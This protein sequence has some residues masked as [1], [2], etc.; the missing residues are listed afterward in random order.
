MARWRGER[1]RPVYDRN[2]TFV[3]GGSKTLLASD[4]DALTLVAAGITVHT[5][6]AAAK[7][8]R[9]QGLAARVSDAY[10]VKPLDVP[11][12]KAAIEATGTLLVVE[13]H[14]RDG[15]LGDAVAA[16]VGRLGRIFHLGVVGEPHS[17]SPDELLERHRL[18]GDQIEREALAIAA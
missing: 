15:G 2:E 9:E 12:L 17:A 18:S 16:Q 1:C 11:A 4:E 3:I 14:N 13:D 5:A 6:L 10:S 8:L 7:R